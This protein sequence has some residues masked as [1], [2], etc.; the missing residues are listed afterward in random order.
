MLKDFKN[1]D[2]LIDI[3]EIQEENE[4]LLKPKRFTK[5]KIRPTTS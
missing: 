1:N 5:K 4:E 2:S 3:Q